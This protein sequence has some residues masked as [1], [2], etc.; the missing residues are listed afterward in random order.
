MAIVQEYLDILESK[1]G[2]R[3]CTVE[4]ARFLLGVIDR[5][6]EYT[7]RL[8]SHQRLCME[9]VNPTNNFN[10]WRMVISLHRHSFIKNFCIQ[11]FENPMRV[12]L[13]PINYS[14]VMF[15]LQYFG[16]KC[17]QKGHILRYRYTMSMTYETSSS[18]KTHGL[19]TQNYRTCGIVDHIEHLVRLIDKWYWK[20]RMYHVIQE[21]KMTP[22]YM[23]CQLVEGHMSIETWE[24]ELDQSPFFS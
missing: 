21:Y 16:S 22:K 12:E 13:V 19:H 9:I 3:D 7:L 24:K 23:K 17:T 10:F 15:S 1:G 18:H 20:V 14:A 2:Y 11:V 6:E 5:L 8:W 4:D